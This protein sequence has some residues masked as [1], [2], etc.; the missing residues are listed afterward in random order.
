[1]GMCKNRVF[2]PSLPVDV[3]GL[4]QGITNALAIVDRKMLSR[5]W[6]EFDY[7]VKNGARIENLKIFN[8]HL[9]NSSN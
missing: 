1:M 3:D 2:V 7:R 5:D 8:E 9:H 4:K 6:K